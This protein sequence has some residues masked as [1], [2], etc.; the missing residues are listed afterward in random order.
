MTKQ[1][2]LYKRGKAAETML[3]WEIWSEGAVVHTRHG[4]VGGKLQTTVGNEKQGKNIGRS[5]ETTPVQQAEAEALAAW[6]KRRDRGG[7]RET[8]EWAENYLHSV[9]MLAHKYGDQKDKISFPV[10]V[11][12]K[13][14]GFR[15]LAYRKD[16]RVVLQGRKVTFYTAPQHI[17][18]ELEK[19]LDD[20]IVLDGELYCH[21]LSLQDIGS[22][23]KKDHGEKTLELEYHV[24][25]ITRQSE[26]GQRQDNR[27]EH[28]KGWFN[29]EGA[30]IDRDVYMVETFVS[31][32][33]SHVALY[34][35]RFA[36]DGYEGAIIRTM[37]NEYEFDTRSRGLLKLK[38]FIDEEFEIIG[39][40][41][42]SGKAAAW[43]I[44]TCANEK[45]TKK[46]EF[47]VLPK[48]TDAQKRKMLKDGANLIGKQL[49]VRFH[50]WSPYGQPEQPRGICVRED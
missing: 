6:T 31:H 23:V 12:P 34:H 10:L 19:V 37:D 13:L 28:L 27:L 5:N 4:Q 29:D 33:H 44:F 9:P 48:G 49:T 40:K 46:K 22:R 11:Q 21:G 36:S 41:A 45:G 8:K 15:C 25:D 24:Y 26:Q 50:Q 43:P 2:M 17:I 14:D 30:H 16:G 47:D 1:P 39:V 18:Q 32:T 35:S 7:Y 42:G 38:D 20:D 3:Q